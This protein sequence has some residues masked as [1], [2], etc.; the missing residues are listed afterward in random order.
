MTARI[1]QVGTRL[2]SV[3]AVDASGRS[4]SSERGTA[5]PQVEIVMVDSARFE[6]WYGLNLLNALNDM[7][8]LNCRLLR[9]TTDGPKPSSFRDIL[10]GFSLGRQLF[11]QRPDLVHIQFEFM[12]FGTPLALPGFFFW[13]ALA[14]LRG[15]SIVTTIHGPFV[16]EESELKELSFMAPR[17]LFGLAR[18]PLTIAYSI[19][20]RVSDRIVVL[21]RPF[22]DNLPEYCQGKVSII[23]HGVEDTYSEEV[24]GGQVQEI[25]GRI[26]YFGVLS[27]RKGID[28]LVEAF[29]I[30]KSLIPKSSLV[31]AGGLP[32]Y[33]SRVIS[34][35]LSLNPAGSDINF[36][37]T[38]SS[39]E[40]DMEFRKAAVFVL[41]YKIGISASGPLSLAMGYGKAT[42]ATRTKYFSDVLVDGIDAILVEPSNPKELADAIVSILGD[43]GLASR[44]KKAIRNKGRVNTWEKVALQTK[45]VYEAISR[46]RVVP[47]DQGAG[48]E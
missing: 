42:I 8:S 37:G 33:Y 7:K 39:S 4:K 45:E 22:V 46:R 9:T 47:R 32:A 23:P 31:V 11:S 18:V 30:V 6:N 40:L 3:K 29:A 13:V 19:I 14:R 44:L 16:S 35:A 25:P 36:R 10:R 48:H 12:M 17:W 1:E 5:E 21:A 2:A 27:P 43:Q 20:G 15:V 24:A 26:L 34:R 28:D 38:V 41:P